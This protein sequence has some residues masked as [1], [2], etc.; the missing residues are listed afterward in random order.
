MTT[1]DLQGKNIEEILNRFKKDNNLKDSDFTYEVIQE[2]KKGLFGIFGQDALVRFKVDDLNNRIAHFLRQFAELY[3]LE[4]GEILMK[5]DSQ[6]VY[7]EINN[8]SDPGILIWKDGKI[9]LAVQHLLNQIFMNNDPDKRVIILD[10]EGYK[11][12]NENII[13]KKVQSIVNQIVKTRRSYTMD[14][15]NA[16]Q[17]R[18]VHNA[19]KDIPEIKTM[20]IGDGQMKRIVL[21]YQGKRDFRNNAK[22]SDQTN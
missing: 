6:Y 4:M 17:R 13:T 11:E 21:S 19:I 9:L 5:N 20:T 22:N 7:V 8:V 10:V 15:M 16:S 2:P 18:V 12:R 14:P 1:I 3:Q